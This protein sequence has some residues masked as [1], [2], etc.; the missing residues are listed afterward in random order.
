MSESYGEP[1]ESGLFPK[2]KQAN[3][4]KS[5]TFGSNRA[6]SRM[7]GPT[8]TSLHL[9]VSA[10]RAVTDYAL[11]AFAI[12]SGRRKLLSKVLQQLRRHLELSGYDA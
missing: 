5:G 11:L 1:Y 3:L 4:G 2:S 7:M 8:T 12:F 6:P 9:E 10:G